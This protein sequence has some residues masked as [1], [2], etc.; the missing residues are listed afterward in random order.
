MVFNHRGNRVTRRDAELMGIF[1]DLNQALPTKRALRNVHLGMAQQPN[2]I[3]VRTPW[4]AEIGFR[5]CF[6]HPTCKTARVFDLK[7]TFAR[8]P[9]LRDGHCDKTG[10]YI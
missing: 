3:A 1:L 6:S 5:K 9:T 2:Y 8:K 4:L 7:A 10:Q